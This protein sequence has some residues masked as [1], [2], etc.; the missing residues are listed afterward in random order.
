MKKND[1][2]AILGGIKVLDIT[3][4][5]AGPWCTQS[6]A[7]MGAIVYKVEQPGIGDDLRH[8]APALPFP[9]GTP[10]TDSTSYASVNRGKRSITVDFSRPAGQDIIRKLAANCDVFVENYKGG[11]MAR[12]GLDYASIRAI[13]PGIVYCSITGY[14]QDGPLGSLPGYDPVFQA[15]S[16]IMST[17]G[18]PDGTPGAGPMRATIPFIDIMTGMTA[19]TAIVAALYHQRATGEGQFLDIALLDVA[20][21]AA[22]APYGQTYLSAGVLPKRIGN[23]SALF[24]P[25]G[26]FSCANGGHILIQIGKDSQ[27]K[28]FCEQLGRRDWLADPRFATNEAR[29]ANLEAVHRLVESMTSLREAHELAAELGAVDVPCGPVNTFA[30]AFENP[31]V[32]HRGI[33]TEVI[34]PLHGRMAHVRS[35]LRF[36]ATPVKSGPIPSLGADT[37][38][39]L[40]H[41]LGLDAAVVASMRAEKV[42]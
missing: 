24:A 40:L 26:T 21:A 14:G 42:I 10:S 33:R 15:I 31:Q 28:R 7:E 20:L 17:C 16:G 23:G 34:H 3:R 29:L 18:L 5:V 38:D 12:H 36:S 35:P 19:T 32:K 30:E 4:V 39:V 25:S 41:E 27:W 13:N 9:D 22:A 37:A 6:L 8:V 2:P 1:T 11:N